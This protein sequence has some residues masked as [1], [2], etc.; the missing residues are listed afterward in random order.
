MSTKTCTKDFECYICKVKVKKKLWN[1]RRHMNKHPIYGKMILKLKCTL[2]E[3][4]YSN[5]GNLKAHCLS[6]HDRIVP[7]EWVEIP[8][9]ERFKRKPSRQKA[10]RLQKSTN[11]EKSSHK[12]KS[13]NDMNNERN[14]DMTIPIDMNNEQVTIPID[15]NNERETIPIDMDNEQVTISIDMHNERETIPIDME[16]DDNFGVMDYEND[17]SLFTEC[18]N[19]PIFDQCE[20]VDP[21]EPTPTQS[22]APTQVTIMAE[23]G[24][25]ITV[26]T[27]STIFGN[28]LSAF[29]TSKVLQEPMQ[30]SINSMNVSESSVNV[31]PD[32]PKEPTTTQISMPIANGRYPFYAT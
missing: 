9:D 28:F 32:N 29:A 3:Q 21:Q 12:T 5:R 18:P 20:F 11:N 10:K 25:F 6:K 8:E 22:S 30:I 27:N 1:L 31:S 14:N 16:I 19:T 4:T 13:P 15:M 7:G 17:L 2:C 23:S 26:T 24:T